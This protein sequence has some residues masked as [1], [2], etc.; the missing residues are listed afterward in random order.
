MVEARQQAEVACDDDTIPL[1]VFIG[2]GVSDLPAAREAD[3]LFARRG[4]RLEEYCQ[5]NDISTSPMTPLRISRTSC[6]RSPRRTAR[7]PA[8]EACRSG[9][10]RVPICGGACRAATP[11][12]YMLL[13]RHGTRGCSSG[14]MSS[15]SSRRRLPR[16]LPRPPRLLSS[17]CNTRH[18][19]AFR[20]G[21]IFIAVAFGHVCKIS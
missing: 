11:C 21:T 16:P 13:A 5:E 7:P 10:T 3:V 2:D 17:R 19:L 12:R 1:I 14:L 6:R 4:L 8:A 9:S 18:V 15:R 20:F